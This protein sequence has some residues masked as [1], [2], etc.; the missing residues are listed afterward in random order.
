MLARLLQ[1]QHPP[2]I[3]LSAVSPITVSGG[4]TG[5]YM[6]DTEHTG[7]DGSRSDYQVSFEME[8]LW[9]IVSFIGWKLSVYSC[10]Y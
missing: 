7:L 8:A 4:M 1:S 2:T 9:Y 5:G 6:Q 10:Q 3:T